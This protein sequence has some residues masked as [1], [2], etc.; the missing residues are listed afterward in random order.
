MKQ[1]VLE[2]I[3]KGP[4]EGNEC[5]AEKIVSQF[6]E[7]IEWKDHPKNEFNTCFNGTDK[8]RPKVCY[9]KKDKHYTLQE[10]FTYWNN[11]K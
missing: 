7:F 11:H 8:T 5:L 2:M 10:L 3:S 4:D 1:K 6:T 9:E